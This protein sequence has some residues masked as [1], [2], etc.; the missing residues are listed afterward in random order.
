MLIGIGSDHGGFDMKEMLQA[1]LQEQGYQVKD[2]GTYS[3]DSCD[4]P[5]FGHAVARAVADGTCDLG[6]VICTTG[7]G[8]SMSANK[9]P[10]IRCALCSE[11][12]S[13]KRTRL[14]NDANMLALGRALIGDNMEKEITDVFLKTE[15]SGGER[16][17]RRVDLIDQIDR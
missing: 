14:H 11:P 5:T 3:K 12:L 17:Q 2:F 9:V 8:I 6:I 7:I 15:F 13:A 10:G 4:Y 16:H 1:Y